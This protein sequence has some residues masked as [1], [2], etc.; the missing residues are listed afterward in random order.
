MLEEVCSPEKTRAHGQEV[1]A[2]HET[3][4]VIYPLASQTDEAAANG[5]CRGHLGEGIIDHSQKRALDYK[6]Q[7]QAAG[8]SVIETGSNTD[9]KGCSD[10]TSNGDQLNL[11]I[12]QMALKIVGIVGHQ[13]FLDVMGA[14]GFDTVGTPGG[15]LVFV[16]KSHGGQYHCRI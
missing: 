5:E 9:E 3:E 11:T 13:A 1:P 16:E 15:F 8:A 12:S 2:N 10:R 6:G 14:V 7:K 4:S